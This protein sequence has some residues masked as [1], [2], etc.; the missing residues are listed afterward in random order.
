MLDQYLAIAPIDV[1]GRQWVSLAL[2]GIGL[3][4]ELVA[5]AAFFQAR[6]TV[7]PLRPDKATHLVVTGL[8]RISRNPMYLGLAI[9]LTGWG[10]YLGDA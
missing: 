3:T 2:I 7:N 1:P 6:T 10:L 5:I 9:L 8:Y 4:I